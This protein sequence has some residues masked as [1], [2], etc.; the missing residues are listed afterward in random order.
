MNET[1]EDKKKKKSE[2]D[3]F[4]DF[5]KMQSRMNNLLRNLFDEDMSMRRK[6]L[7][8]GFN[9]KIG[10]TG[11]PRI[12]SFGNV[13]TQKGKPTVSD[14]RAPLVDVIEG[15]KDI[16][17]TVELPG[18]NKKDI[19]FRLPSKKTALIKVEG[20][21][22]FY[23]EIALPKEVKKK[24]AKAKFKNGVL[25]VRLEKEKASKPKGKESEVKIE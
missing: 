25:E 16:T 4:L 10:P 20:E 6:P 21:R 11:T 3:I 19:K 1:W 13:R 8:M 14:A 23:K 2:F 9:I 24:S 22:N 12:E 18:V 7:V 17:I 5:D 15:E